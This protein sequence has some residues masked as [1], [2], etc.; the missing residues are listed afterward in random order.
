MLDELQ[1]LLKC[2][3]FFKRLQFHWTKKKQNKIIELEG[4]K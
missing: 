3:A 4:E 1:K 2:F